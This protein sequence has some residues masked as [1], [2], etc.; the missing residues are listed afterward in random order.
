MLIIC[1]LALLSYQFGTPLI[2]FIT[3]NNLERE[4]E[5]YKEIENDLT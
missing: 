5:A 4:N 3:M 1:T 2:N